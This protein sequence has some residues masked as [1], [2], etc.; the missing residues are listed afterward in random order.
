VRLIVD[1]IERSQAPASLNQPDAPV[2]VPADH[3]SVPVIVCLKLWI[4]QRTR[5]EQGLLTVRARCHMHDTADDRRIGLH[6]PTLRSWRLQTRRVPHFTL[7]GAE[8]GDI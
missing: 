7:N 2:T 4:V 8:A 1:D 6:V 3:V 5:T